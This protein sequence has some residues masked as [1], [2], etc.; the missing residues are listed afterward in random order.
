MNE[1]A[2]ANN[3]S[4]MGEKSDI[5]VCLSMKAT[6]VSSECPN[7]SKSGEKDSSRQYLLFRTA[8]SIASLLAGSGVTVAFTFNSNFN[9]VNFYLI[10]FGFFATLLGIFISLFCSIGKSE[11][12]N[13][14]SSQEQESPTENN[15]TKGQDEGN[16][17]NSANEESSTAMMNLEEEHN[18]ESECKKPAKTAISKKMDVK[19]MNGNSEAESISLAEIKNVIRLIYEKLIEIQETVEKLSTKSRLTLKMIKNYILG[20]DKSTQG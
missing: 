6:G 11:K 15:S 1:A 8:A 12:F 18:Y 4:K 16:Y 7:F 3:Y 14:N 13:K 10:Y 20:T 5:S 17:G 2:A 19:K 9:T